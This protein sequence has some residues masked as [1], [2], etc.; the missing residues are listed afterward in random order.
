MSRWE[1]G[2]VLMPSAK[3]RT[4]PSYLKLSGANQSS[5]FQYLSSLSNGAESADR[6][7]ERRGKRPGRSAALGGKDI[8]PT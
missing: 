6:A 7:P 2:S 3:T 4:G 5:R 1:W 8:I